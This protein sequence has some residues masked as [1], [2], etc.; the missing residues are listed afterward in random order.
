MTITSAPVSTTSSTSADTA[1]SAPG[2]DRLRVVGVRRRTIVIS[3]VSVIA[4]VAVIA[5]GWLVT[6]VRSGDSAPTPASSHG[7]AG[8]LRGGPGFASAA[9]APAVVDL[10]LHD[11][12]HGTVGNVRTGAGAAAS[13][14][15]ATTP[16][17][18]SV[19]RSD[20]RAELVHGAAGSLT[21]AT[22]AR[23]G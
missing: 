11:V 21:D 17:P 16:T 5:T 13:G 8:T 15:V 14:S 10:D 20:D 3:V 2:P 1:A 9:A 4:L 23:V 7:I 19:L 18:A 12:A 22:G 6:R